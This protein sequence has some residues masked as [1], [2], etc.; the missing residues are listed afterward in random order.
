MT[1]QPEEVIRLLNDAGVEYVVIGGVAMVAHGSARAT[2][3]FDVCYHR[4]SE[5]IDRLC[6]ALA[7]HHPSLRGAPHGLPFRFEPETVKAGLNFT[8]A[9]DLGDIDLLG[10]VAGLGSYESV[11][12]ASEVKVIG[13]GQCMVLSIDGLLK[14]KRAI[15]RKKDMDGIEEL[16]ALRDLRKRLGEF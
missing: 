10:E 5:N 1:P 3:D 6:R 13:A 14:T 9:T 16:E 8:L 15:A 7:P 4:S 12:G 2:F 11:A